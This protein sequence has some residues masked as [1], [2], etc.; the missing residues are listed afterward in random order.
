MFIYFVCNTFFRLLKHTVRKFIT[1]FIYNLCMRIYII[2][3][4][5][6]YTVIEITVC[7]AA[8]VISRIV[9]YLPGR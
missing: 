5:R 4:G 2:C 8:S 1:V 7:G 6:Y 3:T 9:Q